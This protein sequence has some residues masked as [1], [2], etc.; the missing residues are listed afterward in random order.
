MTG[1][2]HDEAWLAAVFDEHA[3]AV[4][5]YLRR[6]LVGQASPDA[7]ADDLTAEVFAITWRRRADV[8]EPVL[9]WLYGVARRVLA[10]HLR[11]VVALPIEGSSETEPIADVAD[12]VTDDLSLREAW[13]GLSPRDREVLLLAAWE[14]LG[15]ADIAVTLGLSVGG[16]SA[17]LARARRR[18]R[19]ALSSAENA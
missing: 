16:A 9:A 14:G 19:D 15:E 1:S 13:A 10:K 4:R 17:A 11:T 5:R 2:S 7:D 8:A 18:F 3:P 6:R 12:L